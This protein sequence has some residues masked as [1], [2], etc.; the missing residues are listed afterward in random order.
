MALSLPTGI[1]GVDNVAFYNKSTGVP[2]GKVIEDVTSVNLN[3][4]QALVNRYGGSNVFPQHVSRGDVTPE[5]SV[6]VGEY[7]PY[8]FQLFFGANVTANSAE[9]SGNTSTLLNILGTSAVAA[10]GIATASTLAGSEADLKNAMYAVKV[11][12]PTTVDVYMIAPR[13]RLRGT[14]LAIVDDTMKITASP[15]TITASTPVTIP[16][17]G[18]EL[19]G[20]AGVIGMT[21]DDTAYF[22]TRSINNGSTVG[23]AG[24]STDC[25]V[26][27]GMVIQTEID[28]NGNQWLFEF[29][30]VVGGGFPIPA[31]RKE[32]SESEIPMQIA[33]GTALDGT[34]SAFKYRQVNAA[35][36]CA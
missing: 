23:Y 11:V 36:S 19:T 14:D 24:S 18:V 21:A 4:S 13:D 12:S 30:N 32:Y 20:G 3:F 28:D 5:V 8:M 6:T 33:R 1:F 22:E 16:G 27:F 34:S 2:Y 25:F 9:A 29:P 15:L 17:T 7:I 35:L 31:T 26:N 10:T